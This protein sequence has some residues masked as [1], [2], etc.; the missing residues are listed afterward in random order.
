L[1]GA[2]RT[3]FNA[4]PASYAQVIVDENNTLF[5]SGNGIRR[6]GFLAGSLCTMVAIDRDKVG[7]LLNHAYQSRANSQLM[8]LFARQFTRVAPHTVIFVKGQENFFHI[9]S[10]SNFSRTHFSVG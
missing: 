10:P 2:K 9:I 8:L 4:F 5:I 7:R 3:G 1:H 6:A